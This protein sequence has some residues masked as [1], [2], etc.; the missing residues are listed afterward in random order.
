M[1]HIIVEKQHSDQVSQ[2]MLH[3][4]RPETTRFF[5]SSVRAEFKY[6]A[7]VQNMAKTVQLKDVSAEERVSSE[8]YPEHSARGEES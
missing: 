4:S 2:L 8:A 7:D 6:E 3:S 1:R 5:L